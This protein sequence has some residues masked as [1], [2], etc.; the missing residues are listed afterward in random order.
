VLTGEQ[1][2]RSRAHH[3]YIALEVVKALALAA[4]A[5]AALR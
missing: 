2:A 1:G 5:W 4:A 3:G